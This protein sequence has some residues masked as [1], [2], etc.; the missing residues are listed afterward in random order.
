MGYVSTLLWKGKLSPRGLI[1]GGPDPAL[2]TRLGGSCG[3][4]RHNQEPAGFAT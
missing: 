3:F 4:Q 2:I 1:A